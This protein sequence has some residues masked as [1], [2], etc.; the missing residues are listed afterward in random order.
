MLGTNG[1]V[2][3]LMFTACVVVAGGG[4][5]WLVE[6]G[7]QTFGDALWW[8]IVTTTTVG[9]GDISPGSLLGRLVAVSLMVVGIGTIG[10]ITASIATYFL[11]KEEEQVGDPDIAHIKS[12]LDQW[13]DLDETER[14]QVAALLRAM[15]EP[16]RK[17]AASA[18]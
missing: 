1:L 7:M 10:M 13:D 11:G 6:P 12:R 5:V 17:T 3:V 4:L 14:V 9:Y 15:A 18:G 2:Y 16:I 8:S